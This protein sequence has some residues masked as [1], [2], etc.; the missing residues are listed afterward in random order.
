MEAAKPT[1][2]ATRR[3]LRLWPGV[4]IVVLMWAV[5]F[6][7]P[8]VAPNAAM[9]GMLAGAVGGLAIATWWVLFSRA[10]WADRL[11]AIALMVVG[12]LATSRLID[13]SLATAGM[14]MLFAIYAIPVLGTA[15]V[16][17]AVATRNLADGPRRATMVVA[18]ALACGAFTLIRT[19]GI[20]NS[21]D[22]DLAWRWSATPE[23]RL[24]AQAGDEP[25]SAAAPPSAAATMD[26]GPGWPGFRGPLRDGIV[27][28]VRI[29]ADWSTAPPVELWRRPVGPG[30]ASF[31]VRGDL[32]Y[33]QEQRGDHEVVAA[34]SL[35]SG[36]PVWFHRNETRF[37]ES[38]AGAGP[39]GTP[40]LHGDR[41]YTFGG[42]GVLNVLD[43]TDGSVAWSR[44]V[45][46]DTGVAVPYWGFASSPLVIDDLVIVAAAGQLAAYDL[47]TGDPRWFG[48]DG[49]D[50]YSSPHR[51][52][53]DG[54]TQVL[55]TSIA[56]VVGVEPADGTVLW[57]HD[58][59]G[60]TRIVQPALTADGDLLISRGVTTGMRRIAVA[61]GPGGWTTEERW[62]SNRLK[63]Y[64][65]DFVV[66]DGHAYGFDGSILAC[67]DVETGERRWKGGRY[68]SGQLVLLH[69][70][71]VLLVVTEEGELALVEARPD[72]FMELG[73]FPA[74]DGKTWNHPV[75]VGDLL[76]VRN[77]R[78]MVVFRLKLVS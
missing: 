16:L 50:G 63:P 31:A 14:G 69:D 40:T 18:I 7:L 73:R 25:A 4:S 59:P 47:A 72:G 70:Q 65:S 56:G 55:L 52:T 46:S 21:G 45:G 19:G 28:G 67:I 39:R 74:L 66:H 38:N 57:E 22:S 51:L 11:G 54:V 49:G 20:N 5:S 24:L 32:L 42:T 48:P 1:D 17:W 26:T 61:Q 29:D 15:L 12:L 68:G 9:F 6:G 43:A 13:V 27:R 58:W 78:E 30:W 23:E 33:T 2:E 64:F 53:I 35:A 71:D 34:Y 10:P 77:D 41:V 76:L 60:S 36:E 62:E 75:L 44:D 8:A 37:W 3:P